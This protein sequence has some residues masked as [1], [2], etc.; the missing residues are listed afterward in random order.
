VTLRA[1]TAQHCLGRTYHRLNQDYQL[2]HT[3]CYFFLEQANPGYTRGDRVGLPFLVEMPRLYERFVAAWL[4]AHLDQ[5]WRL[6]IQERYPI[7]P[8]VNLAFTID[9]VLYARH[10]AAAY[11]VLDTKYKTPQ[12]PSA[13]DIAQ[14][15][16]Y[17]QAKGAPEAA[18]I[19]P[20]ELARP[21]D[22]QIGGVRVRSLSFALDGDLDQ[23]GECLLAALVTEQVAPGFSGS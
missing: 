19:Y 4:R 13:E 18:L 2:I 9:L 22:Q 17:A 11:C 8:A 3:L 12:A 1:Y 15:L 20:V 10:K 16:A 23:A 21:L 5:R 7:N 14:V 6:Q